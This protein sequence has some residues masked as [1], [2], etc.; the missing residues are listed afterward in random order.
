MQEMQ[1]AGI[2]IDLRGNGRGDEELRTVGVL[3]GIGHGQ[4]ALLGV[5]ELK[6]L[7]LEAVAID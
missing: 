6:V 5:L 1:D 7:V 4:Q 2:D 3:S